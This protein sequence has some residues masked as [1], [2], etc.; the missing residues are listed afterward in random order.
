MSKHITHG[1][2]LKG[3]NIVQLVRSAQ[4]ICRWGAYVQH[5]ATFCI[6]PGNFPKEGRHE[7]GVQ[8]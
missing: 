8:H 7:H 5:Y 2:S 6:V 4:N 3:V 1:K